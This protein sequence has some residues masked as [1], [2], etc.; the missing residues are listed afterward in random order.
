[1][2]KAM[3]KSLFSHLDFIVGKPLKLDTK[4]RA[5]YCD[6]SCAKHQVGGFPPN[7]LDFRNI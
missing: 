4:T 1:M 6:K 3:I 7:K 2:L 5:A